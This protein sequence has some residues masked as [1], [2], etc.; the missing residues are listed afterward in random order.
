MIH[1]KSFVLILYQ[2]YKV[3]FWGTPQ[4]T[5]VSQAD[6]CIA[7]FFLARHFDVT[8]MSLAPQTEHQKLPVHE[9]NAGGL[10][11]FLLLI[12]FISVE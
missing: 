1:S 9:R 10:Q 8:S 3:T 2:F 12:V 4:L 11:S 7:R 6:Y 5:L